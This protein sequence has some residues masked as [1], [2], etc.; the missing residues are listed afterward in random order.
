MSSLDNL[1]YIDSR[2]ALEEFQFQMN[3]AKDVMSGITYLHSKDI[4]H[5]DLKPA[6]ILVSNSHYITGVTN[7][8]KIN[9]QDLSN[10]YVLY[11]Q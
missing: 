2:N 7:L 10:C 11:K 3:R 4:A 9:Y 5:K 6:N 8:L 1:D